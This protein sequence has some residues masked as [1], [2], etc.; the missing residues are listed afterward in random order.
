MKW[1]VHH[2][3]VRTYTFRVVPKDPIKMVESFAKKINEDKK[4][5]DGN[6]IQPFDRNELPATSDL[7]TQELIQY[8]LNTEGCGY[9]ETVASGSKD[10][11]TVWPN[12]DSCASNRY[13][14][15]YTQ[16]SFLRQAVVEVFV[17]SYTLHALWSFEEGHGTETSDL[18]YGLG[19]EVS[20]DWGHSDWVYDEDQGITLQL[21]GYSSATTN[22]T[23]V[24]LRRSEWS[25]SFWIKTQRVS[26]RA[27]GNVS[28]L[29][30]EGTLLYHDQDGVLRLSMSSLGASESGIDVSHCVNVNH[31][32]WT[33]IA[34]TYSVLP[35]R[36]TLFKNGQ[37]CGRNDQPIF[38]PWSPLFDKTGMFSTLPKDNSN[39]HVLSPSQRPSR[40]VVF[41]DSSL[42]HMSHIPGFRGLLSHWNLWSSAL[43]DKQIYLIKN[44]YY[45]GHARIVAT[46]GSG[47]LSWVNSTR[48]DGLQSDGLVL[49]TNEV[50]TRPT[51][52]QRIEVTKITGGALVS[53][54][55]S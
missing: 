29:A 43:N 16:W 51:S 35:R 40:A 46:L 26:G 34:L 5:I 14:S 45:L 22:I 2:R 20:V 30:Q 24:D 23:G 4:C 8:C 53:I 6:A 28:L 54:Q 1:R 13:S 27:N 31:D 48:G 21:D 19:N 7:I 42:T 18:S 32:L 10:Q 55:T 41:G 49:T 33:H 50:P 38:I 36:V 15:G 39:L 9:F 44:G 47:F 52:P 17:T 25:S 11:Q 3:G 37:P 12:K